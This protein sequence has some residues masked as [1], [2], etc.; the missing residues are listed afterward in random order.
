[1]EF[2][3]ISEALKMAAATLPT[4]HHIYDPIKNVTVIPTGESDLIQFKSL[5]YAL[6]TTSFVE[7]LGGVFFLLTAIYVVNDKMKVEK[8]IT[9]K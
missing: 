3:Q 2:C 7:V 1:M 4:T 8:F 9:G 5:Q 6:F